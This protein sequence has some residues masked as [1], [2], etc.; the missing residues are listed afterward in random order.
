MNWL[1]LFLLVLTTCYVM[2][3]GFIGKLSK[4]AIKNSAKKGT[5]SIAK[6]V[7]LNSALNMATDAVT[8][9]KDKRSVG[10]LNNLIRFTEDTAAGPAKLLLNFLN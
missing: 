1:T 8:Y 4:S 3:D 7:A 2:V 10:E 5:S 9:G 6:D